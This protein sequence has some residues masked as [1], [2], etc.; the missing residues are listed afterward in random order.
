MGA[1]AQ[2]AAMH[3]ATRLG[4]QPV[5]EFVAAPAAEPSSIRIENGLVLPARAARCVLHGWRD[6]AAGHDLLVMLAGQQ[7]VVGQSGHAHA[8]LDRARGHGVERVVTFAAMGTA[9]HPAAEP[10]AFAIAT[11]AALLAEACATGAVS[12]AAGEV[13]G[14]NGLLLAFANEHGMQGLGLLGE[15]PLFASGLPNPKAA[16]AVLRV[17]AQ[18][19]GIALDL[20]PLHEQARRSEAA[21]LLHSPDDLGSTAAPGPASGGRAVAPEVRERIEQLFAMAP[22]D[23]KKALELK[24]ELD[25]HDLFRAY[26]DRFLDLFRQGS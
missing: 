1:V 19:A 22:G 8:L 2:I 25:R 13:G 23:R 9:I 7:P 21:L 5:D 20:A 12:L 11:S 3:L 26:E 15:M 16:A 24:A 10:R 17:F 6:P 18:V 4:M 14:M